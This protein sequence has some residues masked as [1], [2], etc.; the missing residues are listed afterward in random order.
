MSYSA[1]YTDEVGASRTIEISSD[2]S[3]EALKNDFEEITR[4]YN[5][6]YVEISRIKANPGEALHIKVKVLAPSHYLASYDD[7]EPKACNSM[8]VDIICR[9]G[10]PVEAIRAYYDTNHYLASPNVFRSGSACI[11]RWIPFK[12]SLTTVVDKLI[13]DMVHDP[14]VTRYDSLANGN[15]L[16]WHK[17]G[18]ASNLFPTIDLKLLYSPD[19]LA[20]PQRRKPTISSKEVPA[21]PGRPRKG[22]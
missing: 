5:T 2:D 17:D 16:Q 6:D 10:Y 12:S 3:I 18:V 13:R 9:P 19:L 20:L 22:A 14:S 7:T 11:D 21:L 15:M 1:I 8:E 4:K